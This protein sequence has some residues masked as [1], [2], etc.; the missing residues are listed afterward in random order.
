MVLA[1][2]LAAHIEKQCAT[3][4]SLNRPCPQV[5]NRLRKCGMLAGVGSLEE[6]SA[7]ASAQ[8]TGPCRD[9]HR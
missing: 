3:D 1:V 2:D 8:I 9:R 5:A 7:L 4:V 6:G